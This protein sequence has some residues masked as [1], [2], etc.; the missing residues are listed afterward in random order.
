M[1]GRIRNALGDVLY[2][3]IL[4]AVAYATL[5]IDENKVCSDE[6]ECLTLYEN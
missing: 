5:R 6:K 1:P 2:V 4:F 3:V